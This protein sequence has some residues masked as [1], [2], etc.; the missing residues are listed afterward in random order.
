[1]ALLMHNI[2]QQINTE[3]FKYFSSVV[4][5]PLEP[6]TQ[7]HG[8]HY[9]MFWTQERIIILCRGRRKKQVHEFFRR[10][11]TWEAFKHEWQTSEDSRGKRSLRRVT[12]IRPWPCTHHFKAVHTHFPSLSP[13]HGCSLWVWKGLNTGRIQSGISLLRPFILI[14][15][16]KKCF[17][18]WEGI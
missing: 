10:Y 18:T 2:A 16:G 8:R 7:D 3:A 17:E 12:D 14:W 11:S 13:N 4:S 9:Q 6:H 1:M 15:R 5:W